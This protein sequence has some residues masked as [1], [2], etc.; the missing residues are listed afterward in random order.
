MSSPTCIHVHQGDYVV[1]AHT[2]DDQMNGGIPNGSVYGTFTF[3]MV[4]GS[5]ASPGDVQI[6]SGTTVVDAV[7]WTRSTSGKALQLDPSLTDATSN[8]QPSNFC[9]ATTTYGLGDFGTPAVMNTKCTFLPPAGM[10]S[11]NGVNRAIVKPAAGQLVIS[12]FLAN[13]ANVTG[14]TDAQREWFEVANTGATAFDLNELG[15]MGKSGTPAIVNSASC[16]TVAANG[17]GVFARSS[18]MMVN[19]M[20]PR[21]DAT[22][23]FSLVDTNGGISVLDG[24]TVL[25]AVTWTSVTSGQSTQLDPD[26]LTTVDNDTATN[27]CKG[28][29]TYGDLSNMGTPGMANAQCP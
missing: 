3:A 25:D 28:A 6:V 14:F 18:D 24:A 7:T 22:F 13:P 10:C 4:A 16:I 2:M 27:F 21:V 5:V 29:T 15:V 1:F 11:D 23:S 19:G 17:Y 9:D 26:H 20:I 8:D 12:E